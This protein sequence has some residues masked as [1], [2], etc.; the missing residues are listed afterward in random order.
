MTMATSEG[1]VHNPVLRERVT[2]VWLDRVMEDLRRGA[3]G[4]VLVLSGPMLVLP[5]V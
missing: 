1:S 3:R 2:M 4:C 5:S